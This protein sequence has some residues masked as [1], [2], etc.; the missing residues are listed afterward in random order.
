M[1][2]HR[3]LHHTDAAADEGKPPTT[4]GHKLETE[5]T[6]LQAGKEGGKEQQVRCEV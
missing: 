1:R 3:A 4:E 2:A 6:R 5:A